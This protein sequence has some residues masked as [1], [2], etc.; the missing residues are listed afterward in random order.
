MCKISIVMPIFNG[1]KWLEDS[2]NSVL[3]QTFVDYELICVDDSSTDNSLSILR[4]FA[5]QDSRIKVFT[6]NK[7]GQGFAMNYGVLQAKGKYLCFLDQ[8]DKY[9][10]YY[11]EKMLKS[12]TDSGC[13]MAACNAY[14]WTKEKVERVPYPKYQGP[15]ILIDT[16]DKKLLFYGHYFPQWTKIIE[17]EF[18]VNN[19]ITFPD[20]INKAP[21][22]PVHYQLLFLCNKIG[23]IED[24]I[25]YHRYHSEQT[26][27]KFDSYLYYYY[28]INNVIEW[29]K[30]Y[31]SRK[32]IHQI[33][34]LLK[35]LFCLSIEGS[36]SIHIQNK[37]I[38]L[39]LKEYLFT[40]A[41]KFI[42][43][44]IK[45]KKLLSSQYN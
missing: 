13:K 42:C 4:D 36:T 40:G 6:K 12:I 32:Q 14:F 15:E 21:D 16:L 5:N 3:E 45:R 31:L 30:K 29:A 18:F 22:V 38:I 11:L 44:I 37:L 28:T 19:H 1:A 27:Y 25:Y 2:I 41:Y 9:D 39:A 7:E 26:S 17:R 20:K 43:K 33:K 35:P 23:Y 10:K 34:Q 24:C 8:D